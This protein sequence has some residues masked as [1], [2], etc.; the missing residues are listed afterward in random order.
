MAAQF[1]L[2][3]IIAGHKIA[4]ASKYFKTPSIGTVITTVGTAELALEPK[5]A[6]APTRKNKNKSIFNKGNMK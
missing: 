3:A 2:P 6:K 5:P 4:K 1:L